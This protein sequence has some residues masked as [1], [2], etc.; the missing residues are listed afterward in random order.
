MNDYYF[1][2]SVKTLEEDTGLV[3]LIEQ[4]PIFDR[5][6]YIFEGNSQNLDNVLISQ[7]LVNYFQKI[8]IVHINSEFPFTQRMSDHDPIIITFQGILNEK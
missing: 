4:L 7:S 3:N 6:N 5:Y 2:K 8:D 1:S